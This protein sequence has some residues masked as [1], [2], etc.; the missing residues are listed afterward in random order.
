MDTNNA[1]FEKHIA[2]YTEKFAGIKSN[3]W[4]MC[5]SVNA[6]YTDCPIVP[7]TSEF[8]VT[9]YNPA[10]I[11]VDVQTFK[12]PPS[13]SYDVQVFDTESDSWTDAESTL[14]C[15]NFLENNVMQSTYLDCNLHVKSQV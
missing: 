13:P 8:A 3:S 6:T 12:V 10:A 4:S 11:P 14:L 9:S 7:E 1:E 5:S 15:Y 2:D